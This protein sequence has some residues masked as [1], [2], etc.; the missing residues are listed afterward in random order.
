[1]AVLRT[2][3]EADLA[4]L[5]ALTRLTTGWEEATGIQ[6][7]RLLPDE[8]PPLPDSHRLAFYRAAQEA[9]TNIQRHAHAR[10][11]WLELSLERNL[12]NLLIKDDGQGFLS[13]ANQA[14]FGLRGLR[15]R[16]AHLNGQFHVE[17]GPGAGTQICFHLPW[18]PEPDGPL[19]PPKAKP[20]GWKLT[21]PMGLRK[22][23]S[24]VQPGLAD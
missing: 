17:S 24:E 12:V 16:A 21:C 2:P 11:V 4:L 13:E 20:G 5:P 7:N 15:E 3:L 18:S 8:L 6:V 10:Q 23:G 9:L 14:G 1:V 19:L 22:T